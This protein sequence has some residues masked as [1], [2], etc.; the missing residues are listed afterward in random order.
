MKH[1]LWIASVLF[2]GLIW[3]GGTE[4]FFLGALMLAKT[5]HELHGQILDFTHNHGHDRRLWS[6]ALGEKRDLY[7]YL[8]P[9]YDPTKRYPLLI[10]LHG[11]NQDEEFFTCGAK[12]FDK[13]I[14][15]GKFPPV[16]LA[17][18]DGSLKGRPSWYGSASFW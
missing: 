14:V 8:P 18:P 13:A 1:L 4:A 7:V 16:I 9:C 5:N 17:V 3:V 11:A 6:P 12:L 10:Y 15:E 2:L